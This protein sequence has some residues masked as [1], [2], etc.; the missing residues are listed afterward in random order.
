MPSEFRLI[1]E[2]GKGKVTSCH[3]KQIAEAGEVNSASA[4]CS[5]V[6]DAQKID[7][8]WRIALQERKGNTA[9]DPTSRQIKNAKEQIRQYHSESEEESCDE[10]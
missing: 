9:N 10:D 1:W 2:I 8:A 5:K 3:V 7:A 6:E 4:Q